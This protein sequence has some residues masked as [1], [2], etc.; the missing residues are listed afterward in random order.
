MI[1]IS[2][3]NFNS[4]IIKDSGKRSLIDSGLSCE[5][6]EQIKNISSASV[7]WKKNGFFL[8]F[9]NIYHAN[10]INFTLINV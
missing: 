7:F 8:K 10:Q 6:P 4:L 1:L 3:E 5:V 9:P 2:T